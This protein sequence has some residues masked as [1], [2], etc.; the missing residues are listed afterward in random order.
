MKTTFVLRTEYSDII[1]QLSNEQA[2]VL[3]KSIYAHVTQKQPTRLTDKEIA[4]AF[5][6]IKQDLDFDL[7]K[8]EQI[9]AKRAASG[10]KGG[11]VKRSKCLTSKNSIEEKSAKHN[12]S[13]CD[14]DSECEGEC[15]GEQ[16]PG[17]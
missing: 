15:E 1:D 4:I 10:R 6:F 17:P 13:E 7:Q 16:A 11:K 2:G 12:D 3:L 5:A 9:C 14:S 8:Y